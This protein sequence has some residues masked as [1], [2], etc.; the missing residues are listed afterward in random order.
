LIASLNFGEQRLI[1]FRHSKSKKVVDLLLSHGDLLIMAG[2]IQHYWKHEI[3]KTKKTN[4]A[5]N[6]LT[7]P[8]TS[9]ALI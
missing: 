6:N 5:R 9:A 7:F 4:T 3:P 1:K 2:E 8:K